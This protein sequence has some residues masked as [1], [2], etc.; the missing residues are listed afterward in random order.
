MLAKLRI[1]DDDLR[2]PS[3]LE[4]RLDQW[5][6][7]GNHIPWPK[8]LDLANVLCNHDVQSALH[9]PLAVRQT[10]IS[11]HAGA[12]ALGGRAWL[13]KEASWTILCSRPTGWSSSWRW[14]LARRATAT[15]ASRKS[16]LRRFSSSEEAARPCRLTAYLRN[17]VSESSGTAIRRNT[18][19]S[20]SGAISPA[21]SLSANLYAV[22]SARLPVRG[23]VAA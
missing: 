22:P 3:P 9:C 16:M 20:R 10:R 15:D 12:P 18:T 17:R 13:Q 23:Y 21:P 8:K 1:T 5:H 19:Q 14:T 2:H 7:S 11:I 4:R 6:A